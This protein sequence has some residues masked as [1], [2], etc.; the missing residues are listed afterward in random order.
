M[1]KRLAVI[2]EDR[3]LFQKI[4]LLSMNFASC[5]LISAASLGRGVLFAF[6]L[7]IW[8]IDTSPMPEYADERYVSVGR[9]ENARLVRPFERDTLISLLVDSASESSLRLGERCVYF[10]GREIRLTELEFSLLKRLASANGNF[11]SREEILSDVW[12]NDADGGIINVYVHYLREKLESDGEKIIVSSR[13]SG[14]KI[15]E[16]FLKGALRDA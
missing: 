11:V 9:N 13:K 10:K 1:Q 14:Y 12:K 15:D 3:Y 16:K 5:E 7:C 6:D 2:T 4:R 8:D